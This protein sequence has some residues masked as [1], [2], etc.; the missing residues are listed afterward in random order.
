MKSFASLSTT[1]GSKGEGEGEGENVDVWV[2]GELNVNV[3]GIDDVA[4]S[5]V[6]ALGFKNEWGVGGFIE[7]SCCLVL[8]SYQQSRVASQHHEEQSRTGYKRGGQ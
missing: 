2:D 6:I 1:I 8:I 5:M 4:E 7:K 3:D